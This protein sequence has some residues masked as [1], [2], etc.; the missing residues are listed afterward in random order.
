MNKTVLIT[1]GTGFLG[2]RLGDAFK[3]RYAVVLAG[4]SHKQN[5][6]AAEITGCPVMAMDVTNR[7]AVRDIFA[8]VRPEIVIH[9]AASKYVDIAERQPMECID[10]NVAGSQNI[11]RIAIDQG[12]SLVVGIS[13]DKAAPPV[14]NTYGLCKALMER[15]YCTMNG[16]TTTRFVCVRPG[17]IPWSTGSFLPI[18]KK[19]L[20]TT[21]TIGTTGPEM[22]RFFSTDQ[23]VIDLVGTAIERNEELQGK[24]VTR[25]MKAARIGRILEAFVARKRG[26]W[27]R[28]EGRS[29]ERQNEFL[30]GEPELLKTTEVTFGGVKH[31][32]FAP[33]T[34]SPRPLAA[35]LSSADAEQM[36]DEEIHQLV[37]HPPA[38]ER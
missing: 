11:A 24:I 19:M 21:G 5:A 22:T 1:G 23:E 31:Y 34:L 29:G 26:N 30:V 33:N 37:D 3:G 20:E 18:W 13:T 8:Q 35:P 28:I 14:S 32:V 10:V 17:N 2:R 4:R 16:K 6:I 27:R 15:M 7:E 9:A 36:T 38:E 12:V 25:T